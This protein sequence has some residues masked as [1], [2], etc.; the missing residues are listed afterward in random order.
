MVRPGRQ[1]LVRWTVG[2]LA[3]IGVAT[4]VGVVST[5]GYPVASTESANQ[6]PGRVEHIEGTELGRVILTDDA[7]KRLGI[8][9]V[10]VRDAQVPGKRIIPYSAVLY[11]PSGATWTFTN[12][13]P[14][15]Y[16]RHSIT[17]DSIQGAEAVLSD[18]PP[19]GTAVVTVG[20]A[21][22]YGTEVGVGGD[23]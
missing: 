3:V 8:M 14:L 17:V 5:R 13:E 11:D 20:A 12:P 21:E 1:K 15:V 23:E 22:L 16:L 2:V 9:T 4:L 6:P 19:V 7:A 10:P 18:G